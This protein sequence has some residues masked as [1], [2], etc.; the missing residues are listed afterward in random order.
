MT[1]PDLSEPTDVSPA[2][3]S[4]PPARSGHALTWRKTAKVALGIVLILLGLLWTL[5]G[6]DAV[7][8][9]PIMCV[10]NCEPI[11]GGSPGWLA[12][13]VVTMVAGFTVVNVL[14]RRR[15]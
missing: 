7:R 10:A 4:P 8:I 15:R 6:A 11:T 13:G 14:L 9:P 3:T 2:P 12:A 1:Q 5:Q